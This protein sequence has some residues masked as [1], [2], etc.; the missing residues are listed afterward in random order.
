MTT[1]FAAQR[2]PGESLGRAGNHY[3]VTDLPPAQ[4]A[5]DGK[6][7]MDGTQTV[8]FNYVTGELWPSKKVKVAI[9][10]ADRPVA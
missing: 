2:H 3:S 7:S 5:N 6:Q 4:L 9:R 10:P 1:A 8:N